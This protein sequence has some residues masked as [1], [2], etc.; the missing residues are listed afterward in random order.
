MARRLSCI[1]LLYTGAGVV[2]LLG[3]DYRLGGAGEWIGVAC[4]ALLYVVVSFWI[5]ARAETTLIGLAKHTFLQTSMGWFIALMVYTLGNQPE[6]LDSLGVQ[7]NHWKCYYCPPLWE[8]VLRSAVVGL[9]V[10]GIGASVSPLFWVL[11]AR[12]RTAAEP[13]VAADAGPELR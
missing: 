4:L 1:W 2:L 6:V 11:T 13:S 5:A 10:G 3:R 9:V 8:L 7:A 12:S